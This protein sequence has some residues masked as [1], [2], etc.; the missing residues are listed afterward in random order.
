MP[1]TAQKPAEAGKT[2]ALA[3]RE[4]FFVYSWGLLGG[5]VLLP[6]TA[7]WYIGIPPA[8]LASAYVLALMENRGRTGPF[9]ALDLR[10][11]SSGGKRHVSVWATFARI[12]AT[13]LLLPPLAVGFITMLS[14]KRPLPEL[15]T[16]TRITEIDRRLDPRPRRE[17]ERTVKTARNRFRALIL[18]PLA[19]SAAMLFLDYSAPE[20]IS[21]QQAVPEFELP[22]SERELLIQYL[23]LTTIHPEE[24]EYHVRLASLYYR[25]NMEQDLDK[26]LEII[27][28]IDPEHAIL[29]L[30]DTTEF[31]FHM[32]EPADS[33]VPDS[34][35]TLVAEPVVI[36]E[37][38]AETDTLAVDSVGIRPDTLETI[39]P[40]TSVQ[41]PVDTLV[42]PVEEQIVE[43][44]TTETAQETTEP[45]TLETVPEEEIIEP[46]TLV[47]P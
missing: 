29:L 26:E 9:T 15:I 40:E 31:S 41:E 5:A 12:I 7:M 3:L 42:T 25:N 13:S 14:G 27:S 36:I 44:D 23:E 43:P 8:L 19:A 30:A 37:D 16:G 10:Q 6:I 17:I 46:D 22:E 35:I 38:S 39:T 34:T 21:V 1:Y 24:L 20:V 33:L 4:A 11:Y 45:D 28:R 18:A 47:Q 32:L 2:F